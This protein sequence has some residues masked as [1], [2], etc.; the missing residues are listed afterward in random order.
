MNQGI[1]EHYIKRK[2]NKKKSYSDLLLQNLDISGK[3]HTMATNK[4]S[5]LVLIVSLYYQPNIYKAEAEGSTNSRPASLRYTV[6]LYL[7]KTRER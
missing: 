3:R 6:K 5:N 4:H 7:K 2:Q 1:S